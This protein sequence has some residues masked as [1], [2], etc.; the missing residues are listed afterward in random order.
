MERARN[1]IWRCSIWKRHRVRTQPSSG[2][3]NAEETAMTDAAPKPMENKMTDKQVATAQDAG[4]ALE[5]IVL[6]GDLS[7]LTS[8]DRITYYRAVCDSLGLNPLTNPFAYIKLQGREVLYAQKSATDQLRHMYGV[9]ITKLDR[10]IKDGLLIVEA[11]AQDKSGRVD[12][13]VAVMQVETIYDKFSKTSRP[14]NKDEY[15]NMI[16]K[17]VTK[18]KRRVTLSICGLG[19]LDET[20]IE[21]AQKTQ[22]MMEV[23]D[24]GPE[25]MERLQGV[26]E[27]KTK[28]K[29]LEKDIK[30]CSDV[31]ELTALV[32]SS[33][34]II[35][36][37][38]EQLPT[39]YYDRGDWDG[40][41]SQIEARQ[42]Y[43]WKPTR[44]KQRVIGSTERMTI[45][46]EPPATPPP[47]LPA[48]Q[49]VD[50]DPP[51]LP[52]APSTPNGCGT[53][54]TRSPTWKARRR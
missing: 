6:N 37:C 54:P 26:T 45:E 44:H 23:V 12:C 27:L 17:C 21:A 25:V 22:S 4:A 24:S 13:D 20:E 34:E 39:W 32:E 42:N 28:V 43:G 18:A 46:T 33:R 1:E 31:D 5:K 48:S 38:K 30:A 36:A 35:D 53:R 16:M 52:G 41:E 11:H 49:R 47:L 7:A 40:L 51:A 14:P 2:G 9:G 50:G 8:K 15:A 10:T 3:A 19:M 29:A